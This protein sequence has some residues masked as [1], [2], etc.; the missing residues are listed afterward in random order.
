MTFTIRE[1]LKL[2]AHAEAFNAIKHANFDAPNTTATSSNFG[3][4]TAAADPRILQFAL[5]ARF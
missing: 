4:I 2:A 3:K 1:A 5:K